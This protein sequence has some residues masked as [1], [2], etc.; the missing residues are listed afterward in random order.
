[1]VH[2]H[3]G[4]VMTDPEHYRR[5]EQLVESVTRKGKGAFEPAIVVSD[6]S[7]GK[8]AEAQ[9]H[10]ILALAAATALDS[11]RR[12]WLDVAGGKLGD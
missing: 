12:E 7:P 4:G 1:M 6:P 9:M 10:A 8:I 2:R 5:A 11:D 3:K